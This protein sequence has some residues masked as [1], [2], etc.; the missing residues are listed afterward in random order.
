[1]TQMLPFPLGALW[2]LSRVGSGDKKKCLAVL[3]PGSSSV[4]WLIGQHGAS[5]DAVACACFARA[6]AKLPW[7]C[8]SMLR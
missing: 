8:N 6:V 3:G 4:F 1:M 2:L 7:T 5:L